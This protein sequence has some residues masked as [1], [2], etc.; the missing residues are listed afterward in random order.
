MGVYVNPP[1]K[2]RD[3]GRRLTGATYLQLCE[4]VR[5]GEVLIGLFDRG[6]FF[7]AP[8]LFS[9]EEFNEFDRQNRQGVFLSAAYYAVPHEVVY[10]NREEVTSRQ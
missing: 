7:N 2:V 3:V 1:L 5:T 8:H 10:P 4:Q 6:I 9:Q